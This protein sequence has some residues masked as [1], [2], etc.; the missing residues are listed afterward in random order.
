MN[1]LAITLVFIITGSVI[2]QEV[3][4][5]TEFD[6]YFA[7]KKE[8]PYKDTLFEK[9]IWHKKVSH[10]VLETREDSYRVT[11]LM[12]LDSPHN[13]KSQN[14]PIWYEYGS[15]KKAFQKMVWLNQFIRRDGVLRVRINGNKI[16]EETIIYNGEEDKT[17]L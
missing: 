15:Y 10:I 13:Y 7:E 6:P 12:I 5:S 17:N 4:F 11:L 8:Y 1:R 16:T 2:A 9:T 3:P 14:Y